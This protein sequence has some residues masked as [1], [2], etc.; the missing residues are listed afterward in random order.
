[1]HAATA[2]QFPHES[3]LTSKNL[4]AGCL[5]ATYGTRLPWLPDAY[6]LPHQLPALVERWRRDAQPPQPPP[7][8]PQE[9]AAA[10]QPGGPWWREAAAEPWLLK[11]WSSSRSRGLLLVRELEA[12]LA[13]CGA[14]FG[15]KLCC[16]YVRRP[17]LLKGRKFDLRLLVCVRSL[18]PLRAYVYRGWY[19]RLASAAYAGAP[20]HD[21][22]AHF[23]VSKYLGPDDG[24]G[25]QGCKEGCIEGKRVLEVLAAE[26][27]D[28]ALLSGGG[29]SAQ[30][31]C[32]FGGWEELRPPLY[33]MLAD[34]F[35]VLA[36][37]APSAEWSTGQCRALYG[38]D[39][40]LAPTAGWR[41]PERP[42]AEGGGAPSA[43]SSD[44]V[45]PVLVEVNYSPDLSTALAFYP[46]FVDDLFRR[47]FLGEEQQ[48]GGGE[49]WDLL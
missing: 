49:Q 15:P 18:A 47:L 33:R 41:D 21:A 2:P 46:S 48:D 25:G 45:Q 19:A 12:V 24:G 23:T 27:R 39:V 14:A 11:P 10:P 20:L 43:A 40:M 1:M 38:L 9:A 17:L 30:G 26:A 16:E 3:C 37:R 22:S 34:V 8:P 5:A 42:T 4:L 44:S 32:A 31:C 36:A 7:Q 6:A 29:S 35:R 13:S 28:A